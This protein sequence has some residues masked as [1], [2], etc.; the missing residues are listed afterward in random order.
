MLEKTVL[1]KDSARERLC[2]RKTVREKDS[3]KDKKAGGTDF[4]MSGPGGN[5]DCKVYVGNLPPNINSKDLEDVFYKYGG[6][7]DVDLHTNNTNT[8][9]AF[10]EF[11]DAR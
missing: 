2:E 9:F 6:I 11:E 4:V 7:L 10:I 5:N 8:P 1:E 3:E